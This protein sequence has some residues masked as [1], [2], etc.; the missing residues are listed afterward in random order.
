MKTNSKLFSLLILSVTLFHF[1][2][3][4][5]NKTNTDE[6]KS[7]KV[8]AMEKADEKEKKSSTNLMEKMEIPPIDKDR[9]APNSKRNKE[10]D[11]D[12]KI[13]RNT[14]TSGFGY[15]IILEGKTYVHQPNIPALSGNNGF[16]TEEDARKVAI[17]VSNKI[18][19]NIM[20]PTVEKR[21]LDSLGIK[22]INTI[23]N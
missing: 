10:A 19:N 17:L 1:S 15:D 5:E 12:Y 18:R 14:E 9:N 23:K 20:P 16:S 8:P 6:I 3:R 7:V 4:N 2:C 11:I 13:F 22:E 21:E